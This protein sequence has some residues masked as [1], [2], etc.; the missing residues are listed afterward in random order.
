M[1]DKIFTRP[2]QIR[3]LTP[4]KAKPASSRVEVATQARFRLLFFFLLA[5]VEVANN[6]LAVKRQPMIDIVHRPPNNDIYIPELHSVAIA[7]AHGRSLKTCAV[8]NHTVVFVSYHHFDSLF[9]N[10]TTLQFGMRLR[11]SRHQPPLDSK[12]FFSTN[13]KIVRSLLLLPSGGR[14][15]KFT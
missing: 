12:E 1:R 3:V 10:H 5:N 9:V 2:V 4:L 8:G 13:G 15:V 14:A 11:V 6:M 7:Y